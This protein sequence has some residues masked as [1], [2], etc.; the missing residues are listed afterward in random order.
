[1]ARHYVCAYAGT[2][3]LVRLIAFAQRTTTARLPDPP[4]YHVGDIVWQLYALDASDDVALWFDGDRIAG[5]AI[6]EPP[7]NVQFE[8]DQSLDA[9]G[10]LTGEILTWAEDRRSRVAG[11]ADVPV[12]YAMLGNGTLSVSVLDTDAAR[13]RLLTKRGFERIER[14]AVRF[15][16]DLTTPLPDVPLPP[17]ARA[18]HV[19]DRDL[20]ERVD[21][22]CDAWSVWGASTFSVGA[23]RRLRTSPAYVPELD[24][25]LE[26]SG[27]LVS[28]CIGWEDTANG[29]GYFEPVGT[30]PT[31]TGRGYGRAALQETMRRM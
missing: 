11:D 27:K 28:Y 1:M 14:G 12:A 7:L 21:L 25:A 13:I 16:R 8:V 9:D 18:R 10:V 6:F 20:E 4:Y 3:D 29:V 17:R 19:L 26:V 2:A 24:V 5:C 22:H 30:R 15:E 23:Y 31:A